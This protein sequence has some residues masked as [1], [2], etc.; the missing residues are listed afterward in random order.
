MSASHDITPRQETPTTQQLRDV[1]HSKV[2]T[3]IRRIISAIL[4]RVYR[5]VGELTAV[6]LGLGIILSWGVV[7]A[8]D[9]QSS[10]LTILRPNLKIWFA[11]A[12]D[13]RS[14]DFGRLDLAWLPAD[15]HI[16]LTLE[17]A[18]IL[19]D[20][21]K[22]LEAFDLI[23]TTLSR[24]EGA[25]FRPR[26]VN[27]QI[28]GG[29]VSYVETLDGDITVGLGPPDTVG[30]V[31]PVYR[32]SD[33]INSDANIPMDA[34]DFIQV[35]DATIFVKNEVSGIDLMADVNALSVSFS[36]DGKFVLSA[37]G[38]IEQ[39]DAPA[40][41]TLDTIAKNDLSE[42]KLTVN[43]RGA[44]PEQIAPTKGRFWEL[45]GVAAPVDLKANI[46]FS[47]EDGLR[48][49]GVDL[50]VGSGSFSNLRRADKA[51]YQ[52]NEFTGVARLE[53]GAERMRIERLSLNAP[54]L[55]FVSSGFLTELGNL[56]DGDPNSSPVFDLSLE[57][58]DLDLTP[59]FSTPLRIDSL[60]VRGQAD[61]DSRVLSI[62]EGQLSF[63]DSVHDFDAEMEFGVEDRFNWLKLN[64]KMSGILTPQQFI[65]IWPVDAV[66]GARRWIERSIL[67]G[68]FTQ[69][70]GRLSLDSAFFENGQLTPEGV[71]VSFGGRDV[72][73][74]YMETMP[75][76]TDVVGVGTI[77][78]NQLDL[79]LERGQLQTLNLTSGR[80]EI[81]QLV[82]RGGDLIV[83][84]EG[85]GEVS[86]MLTIADNEPFKFA[87]R[88]GVN[89]SNL[90]GR[91]G[92]KLRVTR[93]LL[94][95]F[96]RERITY[97]VNGDFVEATAPFSFG[98]F[99]IK[100]GTVKLDANKDRMTL[101]GPV[102]IGPWRANME[103][104]ETF[105]NNPPPT[106]Y[107]ASGKV[108]AAELD[109]LGIASR[110]W[111]DGSANLRIKAEGRGMQVSA[112]N[113]EVD[114]TE[115]G[116]SIEQVWMK[117]VGEPARLTGRVSRDPKIGFTFENM[118]LFSQGVSVQGAMALGPDYQLRNLDLS[119][120][121]I[122]G[123]IEGAMKIE[124]DRSQERLDILVS[125]RWADVSP[126]TEDMFQT[127][128]STLDIPVSLQGQFKTLVLDENYSVDDATISFV[129]TGEVVAD[130]RIDALADGE[131]LSVS[132]ETLSDR[133]RAFQARI[134][135]ASKAILAFL[136]LGN[137]SGGELRLDAV[138]PPA[139]ETG[140]FVGEVEMWDFR[141]IEA[142]ALAQLLSL[143]S[144]TG[145][146]DTLSSGSMQFDRFKIP[147]TI[148][149][150]DIAI[151]DARLYGPALGMT[152]D[153]DINLD[154]RVLDFD[155]TIV[156]AYTA[157][158]ILGD[159][160]VLGDIFVQEKDGGLFAL[161]YT[162][163]GPFEQTQ[164]AINPLS[165]LTPGFLRQIFKRD[166][167]D[168]DA[169]LKR[170]IEEVQPRP[171]LDLDS[172]LDTGISPDP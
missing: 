147:F 29:V 137:T 148:L 91:G 142:P 163:S 149:E 111:F 34:I 16:V 92:V 171:D 135:D 167:T 38:E 132:V 42:V 129:H 2:G 68:E 157:N 86:E 117:S 118:N 172:G 153:G 164:I 19:G 28:K 107:T 145:L 95:F 40:P 23:R 30:R 21:G 130:A 65:T 50:I 11:E 154:L 12:F 52:I 66:G 88:Y 139:G 101:V 160:P 85:N 56:S 109:G 146:A 51:T 35:Q 97:Q 105:G 125:A 81:P 158:S 4:Y 79:Q 119:D 73:V 152:G 57:D 10:D 80:V 26:L 131:D 116:L 18:A 13:G 31:G 143:A 102:D 150:D 83:H 128:T 61:M 94:E 20:D 140:A 84:V 136:G 98:R 166:R 106:K 8:L 63:F 75:P 96:P 114:L 77:L 33:V 123:L 43:L 49:A 9:R 156:P 55:S 159:I 124:P 99:D 144:L 133:T 32:S 47:R 87:S 67:E 17:D 93:P 71:Q 104:V 120:V 60:K 112:A 6:L 162:V 37:E 54:K 115:S 161:T 64:T 5:L 168:A 39:A 45:Q 48:S 69:I 90:S 82:P 141:L 59:S 25:G 14:A 41:F 169:E 134:P 46:D 70:E 110:G 138:L 165:A 22:P 76:A 155:G 53:S 74:K 126:W 151:R 108:T 72:T 15:D 100:N 58:V 127:R 78:G 122:S 170:K 7:G 24:E 103:W 89:P 44:R 36:G 3:R 121:K 62:S 113:M 1:W 27:A